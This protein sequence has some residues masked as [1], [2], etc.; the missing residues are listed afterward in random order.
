MIGRDE[1]PFSERPA[2]EAAEPIAVATVRGASRPAL[3][4]ENGS[5]EAELIS[6]TPA[7]RLPRSAIRY[8]WERALWNCPDVPGKYKHVLAAASFFATFDTGRDLRAPQELIAETSGASLS[9]VGRSIRYGR[10]H[11]WLWVEH[12]S[13]GKGDCD[14]HWLTIPRHDHGHGF[15]D[16][17]ARVREYDH[18]SH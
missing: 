15:K 2:W 12:K 18:T 6:S 11:G 1:N 4:S 3:R 13:K 14:V 5:G 8:E 16:M 10:E 7:P 9:T 17:K